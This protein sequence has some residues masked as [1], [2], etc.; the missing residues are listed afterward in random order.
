MKIRHLFPLLISALAPLAAWGEL[1][2]QQVQ[3]ESKN[4]PAQ[5]ADL[6]FDPKEVAKTLGF[7][8]HLPKN[9]EVYFSVI[10][11]RDMLSRLAQTEIGKFT[12]EM[13]GESMSPLAHLGLGDQFSI[14]KDVMGEEF[15]ISLGD[16]FG[17]DVIHLNA[18]ERSSTF[19]QF[20]AM[21][22]MLA[23]D[24]DGESEQGQ[25]EEGIVDLLSG[26]FGSAEAGLNSLEKAEVPPVTIG[27]KVSDA[28]QR[29]QLAEVV[30]DLLESTLDLDL[31]LEEVAQQ[32]EGIQFSGVS[33]RG[34]NLCEHLKKYYDDLAKFLSEP[35]IDRLM[36]I[37]ETK[38][39]YLTT[40]VKEDYILIHLNGG[41]DGLDL[42]KKPDDSLLAHP[43][44]GFLEHYTEK[45]IRFL[46]FIEGQAYQKL[47]KDGEFLASMLEGLKSGLSET[48]VFGDTR[49]IQALLGHV[50]SV[51]KTLF[52]M[53]D[54]GYTGTLGFLEDGF[55]M[56]SYGGGTSPL[57]DLT[58]PHLFSALSEME[59]LLYYSN[60]RTNPEFTAQLLDMVDS[61]GQA[62]YLMSE[63]VAGLEDAGSHFQD[64]LE[65]FGIFREFAAENFSEIWTALTLDW[66]QGTG[67][68]GAFVI[69]AQGTLPRVPG[70]PE[71][72]IKE[73]RMP[74]LAYV[75]PLTDRAKLSS[76][77]TKIE[78]AITRIL[79][80]IEEMNG[81]EI[82]MQEIDDNTKEGVTYYSTAIQFSTKDARPVLGLSDG[83]FYLSSSQKLIA[84]MEQ[85]LNSS[86]APEQK[87][88]YSRV[89]F[90]V[91][92]GL[93]EH[94]LTLIKDHSDEIFETEHEKKEFHENLPLIEKGL[95]AFE[96][97]EEMTTRFYQ[98]N[99]ELRGSFHFK[100]K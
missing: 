5:Q 80:S 61:L 17:E 22:E 10:G 76:A 64:Y 20:K 71:V 48:D 25:T 55:K 60:T 8:A 44:L 50:S 24:L 33:L 70:V 42:S 63:R 54:S 92:H 79:K 100:M 3:A 12:L 26:I 28:A 47:S 72:V 4:K 9:T 81:F 68:E 41:P 66:A 31:P 13:L 93:A 62:V 59:N 89:N 6:R 1:S 38:D 45:D 97:I 91:L 98:K 14:L 90:K 18:L 77:W 46:Y 32:K 84:Q 94:W 40:G 85:K 82:P 53:A 30:L 16:G 96:Q 2:P 34:K 43:E 73:G 56:E 57:I 83:R 87:G 52:K 88:S 58:S 23:A 51:E 36:S 86:K 35:E 7:A 37:L 74:R 75:T 21:V 15:F 95:K 11:G 78:Q 49:D 39:S 27:F 65:P 69:D 19:F 29:A 67:N 99:G